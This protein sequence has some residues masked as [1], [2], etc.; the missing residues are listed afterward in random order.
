M[1]RDELTR[2]CRYYKGEAENPCED[3][4]RAVFWGYERTWVD[5]MLAESDLLVRYR[6]EYAA[7][8]LAD[9][10]RHDGVPALLKALLYSRYMYWLAGSPAGF[11]TFYRQRYLGHS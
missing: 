8:G 2:R 5:L 3:G 6:E 1:K 7:A 4:D 9:F 11:R 10:E